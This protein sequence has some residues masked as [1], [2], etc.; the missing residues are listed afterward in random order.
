MDQFLE[1][2]HSLNLRDKRNIISSIV[3]GSLFALGWWIAINAAAA[4]PLNNDLLKASHACGAIATVALIMLNS[5]TNSQLRG[6]S[7]FSDGICGTSF[8]RIWVFIAFLMSFG[9]LIASFWIFFDYYVSKD[10]NY[11][12]GLAILVQNAFIFG[13]TMIFKFGRSEDLWA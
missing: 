8:I 4:Y 7:M 2:I 5:V 1:F 10:R 13:S 6:D 12:P 9:S 3:S 11:I